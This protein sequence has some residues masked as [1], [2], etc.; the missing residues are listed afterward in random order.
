MVDPGDLARVLIPVCDDLAAC[1]IRFSCKWWARV[2][3]FLHRLEEVSVLR[4]RPKF[5]LVEEVPKFLAGYFYD[6]KAMLH[7]PS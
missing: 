6:A 4:A 2:T 7:D 5:L 1:A 3:F